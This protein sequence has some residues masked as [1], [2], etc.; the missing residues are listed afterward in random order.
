MTAN[1]NSSS[2]TSTHP[3]TL[4]Y[5][6]SNNLKDTWMRLLCLKSVLSSP[7]YKHN[8]SLSFPPCHSGDV[9]RCDAVQLSS[10]LT[11]PPTLSTPSLCLTGEASH[12]DWER[13]W[14]VLSQPCGD[15]GEGKGHTS[16]NTHIQNTTSLST[17]PVLSLKLSIYDA[18]FSGGLPLC[19]PSGW[20]IDSHTE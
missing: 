12:M 8:L 13:D 5:V 19:L 11:P 16:R 7:L 4:P 9:C 15:Q 3:D 2:S 1:M 14:E 10:A 17:H 18:Y 20:G 6:L